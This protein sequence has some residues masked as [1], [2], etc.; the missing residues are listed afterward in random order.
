MGWSKK[1]FSDEMGVTPQQITKIV[2]GKANLTL[3]TRVEIQ[4]VLNIRILASFYAL[5]IK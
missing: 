3:E 5:K 2:S 1:K 4:E